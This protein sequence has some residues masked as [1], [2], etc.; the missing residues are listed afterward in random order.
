[1][2]VKKI[3][4]WVAVVVACHFFL[5]TFWFIP[6]YLV[7]PKYIRSPIYHVSE[8][9]ASFFRNFSELRLERG[10]TCNQLRTVCLDSF[11]LEGNIQPGD[12]EI[13]ITKINDLIVKHP[14]VRLICLNSGGG[15]TEEA[16]KIAKRIRNLKFDT[17][18]GDLPLSTIQEANQ[19]G[20]RFTAS[21]ES[22]CGLILLAGTR[23]VAIGDRFIL[24]LHA[25]KKLFEQQEKGKEVPIGSGGAIFTSKVARDDVRKQFGSTLQISELQIEKILIESE[26]TPG[27]RMYFTS[28]KEQMELGFFTQRIGTTLDE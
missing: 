7:Q 21:C 23:R 11:I 19:I 20:M 12:G 25:S 5:M 8:S 22:A 26:R 28:A 16:A 10:I 3:V 27:S 18:V 15:Y 4:G 24:G 1:M 13:F 9:L 14:N 17:C 6:M 2:T